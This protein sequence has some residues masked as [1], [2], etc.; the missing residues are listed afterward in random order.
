MYGQIDKLPLSLALLPRCITSTIQGTRYYLVLGTITYVWSYYCMCPHTTKCVLTPLNTT[1][2]VLILLYTCPHT[3][4]CVLILL[5]T[6]PHTTTCVLICVCAGA[7]LRPRETGARAHILIYSYSYYTLILILRHMC[8][9]TT[10]SSYHQICVG[11]LVDVCASE[12][13]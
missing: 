12:W 8:P 11:I 9:R 5:Y 10:M 1:K 6:C 7:D 13:L 3:T 2:C 4:S